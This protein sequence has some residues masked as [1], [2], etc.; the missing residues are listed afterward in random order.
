MEV[1]KRPLWSPLKLDTSGNSCKASPALLAATSWSENV[2]WIEDRPVGKLVRTQLVPLLEFP[3]EQ[4]RGLGAKEILDTV[5]SEVCVS[6]FCCVVVIY[7]EIWV[8]WSGFRLVLVPSPSCLFFLFEDS[9]IWCSSDAFLPL[10][11]HG[12]LAL[13][14]LSSELALGS[15]YCGR[16]RSC[17]S[18]GKVPSLIFPWKRLHFKRLF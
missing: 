16:I 5:R 6:V 18:A 14:A 11:L 4:W 7:R 3:N 12:V 8:L 2:A 9:Q 1:F 13:K 17:L 15:C 10:R